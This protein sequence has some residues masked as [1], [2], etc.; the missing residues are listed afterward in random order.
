MNQQYSQHHLP[1]TRSL[2]KTVR[3][4][5]KPV[6][7]QQRNHILSFRPIEIVS[8]INT[9]HEVINRE[10][11]DAHELFQLLSG[12]LDTEETTAI[13][14]NNSGHGLKDILN[15]PHVTSSSSSLLSP[16]SF[17]YNEFSKKSNFHHQHYLGNEDRHH[18]SL[19]QL[20]ARQHNNPFVGLL[21]NRLSCT[22][23]GY[24]EAI[25]HS[26]FNNI[27]LNLPLTSTTTLDE[28]L[29]QVT[30]MEYLDDASCRKC[31]IVDLVERLRNELEHLKQKAKQCE[32]TKS[33][34]DLLTKMVQVEMQHRQ[35]NERLIAETIED[36][37][38]SK[39]QLHVPY[40]SIYGKST[41]QAMFAKPPKVLCLHISRSA[42]HPSG[43]IYKNKCH[44][45]FPEYLDLQQ[46][47]T[48]GT[49]H[50]ESNIPISKNHHH[51]SMEEK[52]QEQ[53]Q[54]QIFY[55][56]NNNN[57]S[58]YKLMSVIVHYGSH[59]YGHFIA[60]KRR[61]ISDGCSCY[62]CKTNPKECIWEGKDTWYRISD[63][64]VDICTIDE[65][66]S[67]NP[68]M[69]L[70][71]SM[72]P[73]TTTKNEP[74]MA[75]SSLLSTSIA[76]IHSIKRKPIL[77]STTTTTTTTPSISSAFSSIPSSLSSSPSSTHFNENIELL[78][79]LDHYH[80]HHHEYNNNNN[81]ITNTNINTNTNTNT[82]T[83]DKLQ[84]DT[85]VYNSQIY[86]YQQQQQ[87]ESLLVHRN[88]QRRKMSWEASYTVIPTSCN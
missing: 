77:L 69:L 27:Q 83:T 20:Q 41:K 32:N 36:D 26:S 24:T 63:E 37:L 50:T 25:R 21:A 22:R 28:C 8:A 52:Q 73:M 74:F 87:N 81:T 17:E 75:L 86:H 10:Q 67:A 65:V 57:K 6:D 5:S 43:V 76:T 68:Y 56:N 58:K 62:Q 80:Q 70:Y 49:L 42:F 29:D 9:N 85:S 44:L 79:T 72:E 48:N 47:C 45:Q 18:P 31:S 14:K 78:N 12:A 40:R 54:K 88:Q 23:C 55:N 1:V 34:K 2:L 16:P 60:Y 30:T 33:K 71:E 53:Q 19:S 13:V 51:H 59:N 3:L 64:N 82:N 7:E 66:L 61:L 39:D 38:P 4:L 46:Y 84:A 35:F 11:Q 15:W